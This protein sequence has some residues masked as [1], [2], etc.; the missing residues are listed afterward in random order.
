MRT[1]TCLPVLL[2][3]SLLVAPGLVA[4]A[5]A[6][7]RDIAEGPPS[8][9]LQLAPCEM[10]GVERRLECGTLEV[11][12]DR[13]ARSG[14]TIDISFKVLRATSPSPLPDPIFYFEGGPGL[15]A[16]E[17]MWT[18]E[19]L[20][21]FVEALAGTALQA[22]LPRAWNS[23]DHVFIDVR[24]TGQSGG[25]DCMPGPRPGEPWSAREVFETPPFNPAAMAACLDRFEAR[26]DLTKYTTSLAVDDIDDVR[27]ALGYEA[28]N[29]QGG[30]YGSRLALEYARRHGENVRTV[31]LHG[32]APSFASLVTTLPSDVAEVLE[33]VL[34]T[35]ETDARCS[36]AFPRLRQELD[37]VLRAA[38]AGDVR[39]TV[40]NPA[41]GELES[42]GFREDRIL[43]AIRYALYS[44][45]LQAQF[46]LV[47]HLAAE[48]DFGPLAR[49]AVQSAGAID[50]AFYEGYF[51]SVKCSEE[52]A[53]VDFDQ[54]SKIA[55]GSAMGR[56]R[57]DAEIQ[58]CMRW[59]KAEV[60][61][62]F[63]QPVQSDLPFLLMNG[64][65]DP[66][67]PARL[68]REAIQHLPNGVYVEASNRSH[69]F[70]GEVC[71][72]EIVV[73]FL[74][75]GTT[76]EL[77]TSCA[78]DLAHPP[79]AIGLDELDPGFLGLAEEER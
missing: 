40:T 15:A 76:E 52:L 37:E 30:S 72:L 55:H 61:A 34:S 45:K 77:D 20:D 60:P 16:T 32:V 71:T 29:V 79:F 24:G 56:S 17:H 3:S 19:A 14:R 69:A 23:R 64:D 38:A 75:A 65:R 53:F 36:G 73:D 18:D 4:G 35:C 10:E 67:S 66:A 41:T 12:E 62:D 25:L 8:P 78:S 22:K 47:L 13:E 58:I 26:A 11:F 50:R 54:A 51:A 46:P 39:V 63:R 33:I 9:T 31:L 48:G 2:A 6:T 59:P 27:E 70:P 68:A 7:E 74:E 49:M 57:L 43:A 5:P 44:V 28:I 21:A 1:P 42:T